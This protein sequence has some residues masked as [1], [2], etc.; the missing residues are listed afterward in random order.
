MFSLTDLRIVRGRRAVLGQRGVGEGVAS[1]GVPHHG[2][3]GLEVAIPVD[4]VSRLTHSANSHHSTIAV[5]EDHLFLLLK[6]KTKMR[7]YGSRSDLFRSVKGIRLRVRLTRILTHNLKILGLDTQMA[8][9][10]I[11]TYLFQASLVERIN[12]SL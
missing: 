3:V 4:H 10:I 5:D 11:S 7:V 1:F 12:K 2:L 8:L 6:V 9:E